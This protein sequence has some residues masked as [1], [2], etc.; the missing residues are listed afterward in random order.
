MYMEELLTS[1]GALMNSSLKNLIV[2]MGLVEPPKGGLVE[3]QLK[4]KD[5]CSLPQ[6]RNSFFQ[7]N[8]DIG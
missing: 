3:L 2:E 6:N 5:E 8:W 4:N 7:A 1:L